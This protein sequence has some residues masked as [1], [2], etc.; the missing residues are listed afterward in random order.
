MRIIVGMTQ[1]DM[2]KMHELSEINVSVNKTAGINT[3][4][5]AFCKQTSLALY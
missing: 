1:E 4:L 2:I 3:S 5:V